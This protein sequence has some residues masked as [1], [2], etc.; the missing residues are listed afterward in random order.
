MDKPVYDVPD[1]ADINAIQKHYTVASTFSGGGGSS[2]GY[3]MAGF[4]VVYANEFVEA[5]RDTYK[6][7]HP[8]TYL[9]ERDIRDVTAESL[10]DKAGVKI[11]EL[12][13]L[14]GSPPCAS[15][16]MAG[17]RSK[18]WGETKK[19][20]DVEQR[21]DDL[22]YEYAR[23]VE[24]VR[25]KVFVAE[26]VSGLVKGQ[27][28]G[29]FIKIL[30]R[31]REC[32]YKVEAAVLDAQWLGVPQSR[33][34]VIFI[35]VR[36]DI[37][38]IPVFPKPFAYQYTLRDA[39]PWIRKIVLH[40][41]TSGFNKNPTVHREQ[42]PSFTTVGLGAFCHSHYY[43]EAESDMTKYAIAKEWVKLNPGE[44]SEKY[45]QLVK[46]HPDKPVGTI[47]AEGGNTGAA[48]VTHPYECRKFSIAEVKRLCSFP[49]DYI[50][51]GTYAKQ[52]ERMG[53]SVPPLMMKAI[54][55]TIRKDI[56]HD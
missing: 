26:N 31:L 39:V 45:F 12:D 20:S 36:N 53:R 21:T 24:G 14:D 3:K 48:S 43:V 30:Q 2:T 15:F 49:H 8:S 50:L 38:A 51:T 22:F 7:N 55:K 35:G 9:D 56:F 32:D 5:A 11:G 19:Y 29:Y 4:N 34:R 27:A 33:K 16:S 10:C 28:K 37:D 25:P 1:M 52:W 42:S 40:N 6:A 17:S 46:P 47:T 44:Q 18:H 54:A 23:L 41:K 13:I